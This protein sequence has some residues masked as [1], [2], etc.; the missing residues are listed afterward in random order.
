MYNFIN[1]LYKSIY[2]LISDMLKW[3]EA[4]KWLVKVLFLAFALG[5]LS[6]QVVKHFRQSLKNQPIPIERI[7]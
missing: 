1:N 6:A 4:N 3:Y 7:Y 2:Y 5:F